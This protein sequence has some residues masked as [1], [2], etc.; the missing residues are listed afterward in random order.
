MK[1]IYG[2]L[3]VFTLIVLITACG[4]STISDNKD[5]ANNSGNS[6][7]EN[8][9][10]L[11]A[12]EWPQNEYTANIPQ[13]E[14]GTLLRG[15]I[16]PDKEYCHLELSEITQPESEQ[17]VNALKEAGFTEVE[18]VSEEINDDYISI[19][20]LLTKDNTTVSISYT[21]DLFGMYIKNEQ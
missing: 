13:P 10:M 8:F 1:K 2:I 11:D 18:K 9:V 15:W 17:Y 12:G 3:L 19:G 5:A 16:D 20:T 4:N 21:D 7:P 6:L 14:S